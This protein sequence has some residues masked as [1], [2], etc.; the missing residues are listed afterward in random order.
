[1]DIVTG[2]HPSLGEEGQTALRNILHQS[3]DVFPAPGE[4]VTGRT[5]SQFQT[6]GSCRMRFLPAYPGVSKI[7]MQNIRA[8]T[9]LHTLWPCVWGRC[10]MCPIGP[11]LTASDWLKP[12]TPG[13]WCAA[14]PI[15]TEGLADVS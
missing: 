1:M 11:V 10:H 4:L 3:A 6:P 12:V 13:G 15:T 8:M 14:A 9:A 5:T 2:S 7:V